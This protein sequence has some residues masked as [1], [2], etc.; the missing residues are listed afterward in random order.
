MRAVQTRQMVAFAD[1]LPAEERMRFV[2]AV[3]PAT[4]DRA[5]RTFGLAWF[6]MAEHMHL[7]VELHR[8]IGPQRFR[9]LMCDTFRRAMD[10]PMLHGM[11]GMMRRVS[12][13]PVETLLRYVTR[14]VGSMQHVPLGTGQGRI[15]LQGWPA[16]FDLE[17]WAIGVAGCIEGAILG[18]GA[19]GTVELL[20]MDARTGAAGFA[21]RW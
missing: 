12:D 6:S 5:H 13:D 15:D 2:G 14:D 4:L 19:T 9:R 3:R 20:R 18:L 1:K 7:S 16:E 21:V 11:F 10:T 17:V 8:V